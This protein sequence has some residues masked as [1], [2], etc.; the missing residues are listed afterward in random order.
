M[1][2][3]RWIAS[4]VMGL[5]FFGVVLAALLAAWQPP[6]LADPTPTT[7]GVNQ[8]RGAYN[9][10]TNVQQ[11]LAVVAPLISTIVGYLFGAQG[12]GA[13]HQRADKQADRANSATAAAVDLA[14][15]H[16]LLDDLKANHPGILPGS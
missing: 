14:S 1:T 4:V 11:V 8:A 16:G 7:A 10:F 5:L 9:P 12:L 13:A 6:L 15:R 3:S 2:K